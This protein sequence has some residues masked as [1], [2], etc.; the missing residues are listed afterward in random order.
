MYCFFL[1]TNYKKKKKHK[2]KQKKMK[3]S[4]VQIVVDFNKHVQYGP[5]NQKLLK[6]NFT[7]TKGAVW[8]FDITNYNPFDF[9][10][11]LLSYL[12]FITVISSVAFER[13]DDDGNKTWVNDPYFEE[14]Q[15]ENTTKDK[16][17]LILQK[18]FDR[19]YVEQQLEKEVE[20]EIEEVEEEER[21]QKKGRHRRYQTITP[22][23]ISALDLNREMAVLDVI[24]ADFNKRQG[25]IEI[26]ETFNHFDANELA[27][28]VA[29]RQTHIQIQEEEEEEKEEV[30]FEEPVSE[31]SSGWGPSS[32]ASEAEE[33]EQ[34]QEQQE[35][36]E[37]EPEI[38]ENPPLQDIFKNISLS[39]DEAD[40][41]T[42]EF[43]IETSPSSDHPKKSE[44]VKRA[45][46]VVNESVDF[47][48]E[49]FKVLDKL[50]EEA[51]IVITFYPNNEDGRFFFPFRSTAQSVYEH[52]KAE[53]AST[54]YDLEQRVKSN[55]DKVV[56]LFSAK[57]W[58]PNSRQVFIDLIKSYFIN[59][60][61]F[62]L[63]AK[64]LDRNKVLSAVVIFTVMGNDILP[65]ELFDDGIQET[66]AIQ[67]Y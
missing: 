19:V 34:Q 40:F 44:I 6:K 67:I 49:E 30:K 4:R 1:N 55:D 5:R 11:F 43:T 9:S 38:I 59:P 31:S 58:D 21:P 32:H 61:L 12:Q 2:N 37:Q 52:N 20:K 47:D 24:A 16:L 42:D 22:H 46:N 39:T 10:G 57:V 50:V 53:F 60:F 36:S 66:T 65:N 45:S 41:F 56:L 7:D 51:D 13:V 62:N 8:K 18:S 48:G 25:H 17:A 23:M 33:L 64:A 14:I 54:L 35:K 28:T 27:N 26:A 15:L 3:Y 29:K 63:K